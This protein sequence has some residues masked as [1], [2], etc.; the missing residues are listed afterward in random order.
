MWQSGSLCNA[1]GGLLFSPAR[2]VGKSAAKTHGFGILYSERTG[3]LSDQDLYAAHTY[4]RCRSRS[5][6][7]KCRE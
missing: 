6:K 4:P 1:S 5:G 2:K 7:A 3:I